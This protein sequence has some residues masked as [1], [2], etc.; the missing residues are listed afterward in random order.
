MFEI[1][2]HFSKHILSEWLVLL[3]CSQLPRLFEVV[4]DGENGRL[5]DPLDMEDAKRAIKDIIDGKSLA[6]RRR[7]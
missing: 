6:P 4:A 5:Y 2:Q 3:S 7:V 1:H